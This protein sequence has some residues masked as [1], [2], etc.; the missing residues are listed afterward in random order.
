MI[1]PGLFD[2]TLRNLVNRVPFQPF[3][4]ELHG[5][6]TLTIPDRPVVFCDG[7]ATY[8]TPEF[9][10]V[11]FTSEQVVAFRPIRETVQ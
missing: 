2:E 11:E 10:M 3:I 8:L 5:G 6:T 4:V 9:N 1:D 7:A